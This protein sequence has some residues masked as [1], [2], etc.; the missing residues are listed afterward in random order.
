ML[1]SI[2]DFGIM[3]VYIL[4]NIFGAVGIYWLARVPKKSKH[5]EKSS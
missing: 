2:R 1:T 4:V 3:W 5:K